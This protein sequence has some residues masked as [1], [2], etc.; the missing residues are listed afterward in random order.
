VEWSVSDLSPVLGVIGKLDC[1]V[2]GGQAVNIWCEHYARENYVPTAQWNELKP[3]TSLDLDLLG[4][5]VEAEEAGVELHA[6]RVEIAD[7][8][9]KSDSPI[10]GFVEAAVGGRELGIHF[11]HR[12]AGVGRDE[13]ERTAVSIEAAGTNVRVMHPLLCLEGRV[14]MLL[15]RLGEAGHQDQ[16]HLKRGI[17]VVRALLAEQLGREGAKRFLS[18][19]E[20]IFRLARSY[21][22]LLLAQ[23]CGAKLEEAIPIEA[24]RAHS[25]EAMARFCDKRWPQMLEILESKRARLAAQSGL[26]IKHTGQVSPE[27]RSQDTKAQER[28]GPDR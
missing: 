7:P 6:N 9:S 16:L 13:V 2:I 24:A 17:L 4:S 22:G 10:C 27:R 1:V 15:R 3:F 26:N 8:F 19:A 12:I 20:R 18:G 14:E 28:P 11:L 25:D 21:D 23:Q 5:S